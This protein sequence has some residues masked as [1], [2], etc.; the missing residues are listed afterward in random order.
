LLADLLSLGCGWCQENG[1]PCRFLKLA[2]FT[3]TIL[4]IVLLRLFIDVGQFVLQLF[5]PTDLGNHSDFLLMS[6]S[7]ELVRLL[8]AIS[9][10]LL[11]EEPVVNLLGVW[12][13]SK[14]FLLEFFLHRLLLQLLLLLLLVALLDVLDGH[15]YEEVVLLKSGVHAVVLNRLFHCYLVAQFILHVKVFPFLRLIF[16]LPFLVVRD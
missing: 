16:I 8:V 13:D 1:L 2:L 15:A 7:L 5:L 10:Y 12:Q 4:F 6:R 3:G 9:S 11:G 14:P